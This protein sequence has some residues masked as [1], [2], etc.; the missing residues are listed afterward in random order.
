MFEVCLRL[1]AL[2]RMS[3]AVLVHTKGSQRSFQP[4]MKVSM[5]PMRSLTEVNVPRRMACR[6]MIPKKISINRPW[7]V[8]SSGCFGWF[9]V[10]ES[11]EVAGEAGDD[12]GVAGDLGVPAAGL[13][14]V[15]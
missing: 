2:V 4:S 11:V 9:A 12:A 1:V 13:G 7:G 6:V 8:V 5:A 15:A 3:S 14:V 10:S